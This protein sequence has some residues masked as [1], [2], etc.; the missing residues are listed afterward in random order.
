MKGIAKGM[1]TTFKHLFTP[2]FTIQYPNVKRKL[3]ERSRQSFAMRVDEEGRPACKSCLLCERSCPDNAIVIT[4]EKREDGPGRELQSF[5]IDLGRCMFCGL[6]IE[7]CT[8]GAL[9]PTGDFELSVTDRSGTML[10]LYPG[11]PTAPPKPA[12]DAADEE[13][14]E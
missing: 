4:S 2:A 9:V 6:C 3:P 12:G 13:A 1:V 14:E 7:Q 11:G 5:V 10:V 8:S